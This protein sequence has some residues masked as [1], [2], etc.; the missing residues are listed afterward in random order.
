MK[1]KRILHA[2]RM[3]EYAGKKSRRN[4][5]RIKSNCIRR[6]KFSLWLKEA[7]MD[8]NC[9]PRK[10]RGSRFNTIRMWRMRHNP[11]KTYALGF[12]LVGLGTFSIRAG[13]FSE[14]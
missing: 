10:M 4:M 6:A 9:P 5:N 8:P 7:G 14:G 11:N 1:K 13:G 2:R 12:A 3:M